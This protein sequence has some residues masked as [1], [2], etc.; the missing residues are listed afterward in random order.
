M[1]ADRIDNRAKTLRDRWV[2]LWGIPCQ[3]SA[4]TA[5]LHWGIRNMNGEIQVVDWWRGT[6]PVE[7]KGRLL[8]TVSA[9]RVNDNFDLAAQVGMYAFDLTES[10]EK[11]RFASTFLLPLDQLVPMLHAGRDLYSI[12]GHFGCPYPTVKVTAQRLGYAV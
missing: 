4:V 10:W 3:T 9:Y 2:S 11:A 12:A 8:F 1:E 5:W 6:H 7:R